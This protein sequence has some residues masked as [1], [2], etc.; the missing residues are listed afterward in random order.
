MFQTAVLVSCAVS[1][2]GIGM[3]DVTSRVCENI[4][5][6]YCLQL[7]KKYEYT[8]LLH[9]NQIEVMPEG[10]MKGR[11]LVDCEG[12][13]LEFQ[14]VLAVKAENDYADVFVYVIIDHCLICNIC[15]SEQAV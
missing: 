5:T 6:S 2:N 10:G 13:I 7:Q 15:I 8:D 11:G 3:N 9:T 4:S 1:G 12:R 14:A